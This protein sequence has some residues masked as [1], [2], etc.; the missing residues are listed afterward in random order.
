VILTT[1]ERIERYV[2]EKIGKR[3]IPTAGH[4]LG[5]L[6][7]NANILAGVYFSNYDG[8]NVV[9]DAAA[10]PKRRWLDRRGL[11][12]VFHYAFKQLGCARVTTFVPESNTKAIK[13]NTQVGFVQEGRL[14]RAAPG[15]EAM[16]IF[17]M[18]ADECPWLG[19]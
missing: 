6:D 2:C 14:E 7:A 1:G 11:W 8:A 17:R 9:F 10:E 4:A 18:F 15:G 3:Y 19:E 5:W 13:L 12:A 16:L